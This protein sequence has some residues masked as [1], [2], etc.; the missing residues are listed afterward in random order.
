M[1]LFITFEGGEGSGKSLQSKVLQRHLQQLAI[2]SVLIHEPGCT[3]LGDRV[4]RVLKQA[5]NVS[6]SPL[7][8]LLLF[9]ASRSQLVTEVIQAQLK[10][11]H[12]VIC[13]RFADSTVAYQHFGRGLERKL[14]ADISRIAAQGCQP[15]ITF[16]LDVPP[17]MGLS[18]KQLNTADRFEQEDLDFHTRVRQ[19]FLQLA[20]EEP[21]RWAVID[22]TLTKKRIAGLIW[23]KLSTAFKNA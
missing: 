10:K 2:P 21:Q 5:S 1:S 6:I 17:E 12:I 20:V 23:K 16:L 3:V 4:R 8:E 14:V 9:N 7:T 22:S 18:R 15:D 11:G 19:G 13:D